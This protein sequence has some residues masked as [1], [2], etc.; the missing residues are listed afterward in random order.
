MPYDVIAVATLLLEIPLKTNDSF[1]IKL[2]LVSYK[3]IKLFA[4][5]A[6]LRNALAP[7]F[8]PST[9]VGTDNVIGS[10]KLIS[11]VVWTSYKE[12]FHSFKFVF[13]VL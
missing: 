4:E 9:K 11:T 1:F 8:C 2:P 3:V 13:E 5:T 7:L 12:M 6:S 10:F